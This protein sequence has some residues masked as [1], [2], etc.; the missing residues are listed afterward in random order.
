[1]VQKKPVES[2]HRYQ[3]DVIEGYD[4]L[5]HNGLLKEINA[6]FLREYRLSLTRDRRKLDAIV[7]QISKS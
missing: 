1:M 3:P 6:I 2:Q 5:K 7:I 4:K